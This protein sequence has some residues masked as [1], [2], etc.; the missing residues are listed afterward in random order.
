[1]GGEQEDMYLGL[2]LGQA[3]AGLLSAVQVGCRQVI[4]LRSQTRKGQTWG[5]NSISIPPQVGRKR[6]VHFPGWWG[7]QEVPRVQDR[8]GAL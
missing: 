1:M 8:S 2:L 4:A 5:R 3:L 6:K 7:V